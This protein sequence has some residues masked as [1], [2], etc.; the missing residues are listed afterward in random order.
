M[1]QCLILVVT[2]ACCEGLQLLQTFKALV[3]S[4]LFSAIIASALISAVTEG[5]QSAP[6]NDYISF[7]G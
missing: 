1:L 6:P 5:D 3:F 7:R 2:K 4:K